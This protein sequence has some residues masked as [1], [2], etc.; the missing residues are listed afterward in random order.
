MGLLAIHVQH[1]KAGAEVAEERAKD[2]AN[3]ATDERDAVGVAEGVDLLG[4]RQGN[5]GATTWRRGKERGISG[6]SGKRWMLLLVLVR[7]SDLGRSHRVLLA[8]VVGD[9]AG[10]DG[11]GDGGIE[12]LELGRA[13]ASARFLPTSASLR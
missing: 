2:A 1:V 6:Q 12:F 9:L 10:V 8:E 7:I 4:L 13:H 11:D 5:F 3:V